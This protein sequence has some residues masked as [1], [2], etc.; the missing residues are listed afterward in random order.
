MISLKKNQSGVIKNIQEI[1]K[2]G[3][4]KETEEWETK[5]TNRKQVIKWRL[6]PN[7]SVIN[8]NVYCLTIPIKR[9]DGRIDKKHNPTVCC[10]QGTHIKAEWE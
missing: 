9:Q 4:E 3:K 10:L 5:G 6:K 2:K 7:V 8:L 1:Q